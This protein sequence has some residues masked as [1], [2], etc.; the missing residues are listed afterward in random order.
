MGEVRMTLALDNTTRFNQSTSMLPPLPTDRASQPV[1][2]SLYEARKP[3]ARRV[4]RVVFGPDIPAERQAMVN[5][6]VDQ[7]NELRLL[8]DGWNGHHAREITEAAAEGAVL[9]AS[10]V[11]VGHGARPQVFPLPGGGLQVEWHYAGRDLEIEV[12]S[13]GSL[14]VLAVDTEERVVIDAEADDVYGGA[15]DLLRAHAFLADVVTSDSD[16]HAE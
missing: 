14:H 6:A 12:E 15:S 9:A 7:V 4:L 16:I 11:A 2:R 13:D 10:V 8:T 3:A 5:L 1:A